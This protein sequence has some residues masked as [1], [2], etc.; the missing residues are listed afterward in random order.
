MELFVL[1]SNKPSYL[2]AIFRLQLFRSVSNCILVKK[3]DHELWVKYPLTFL[4]Y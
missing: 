4:L 3:S 1:S 2:Y